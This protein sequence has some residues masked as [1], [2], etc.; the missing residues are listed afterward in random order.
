M[1]EVLKRMLHLARQAGIRPQLL[2]LDRCFYSSRSY[3]ICTGHATPL[4]C[5]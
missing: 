5:R 1:L 3:G 2:L 4:L